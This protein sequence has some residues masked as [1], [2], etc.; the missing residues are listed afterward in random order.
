MTKRVATFFLFFLIIFFSITNIIFAQNED[1]SPSPTAEI[2]KQATPSAIIKYNLAFPGILPD[3]P[4]YKL[5]V[6]RDKISLG[7]I[8]DPTKKIE[9]LLLQTDKG[10]LATAMLVD[11]NKITLAKETALK[12]ENNYTLLTYEVKNSREKLTTELYKKLKKAALKH[13]EVLESLIKRVPKDNRKTFQT[14]LC[15]SKQNWQSVEDFQK[16]PNIIK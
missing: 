8:S 1:L 5:K 11:Q 3:N 6:L 14:V 13:Q 12:A 9:F 7:L 15:F 16:K 10:I 2:K 4:L